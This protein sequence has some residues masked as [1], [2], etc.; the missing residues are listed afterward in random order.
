M[1]A[2]IKGSHLGTRIKKCILRKV[3]APKL[4]CAGEVREGSAKFV[5]QLETVH[6]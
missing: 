1:D 6:R 2:T 5:K 4:E 3:I